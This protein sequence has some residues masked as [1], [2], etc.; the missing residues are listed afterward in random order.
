MGS[1]RYG[2][3]YW[4]MAVAVTTAFAF[5]MSHRTGNW[6]IFGIGVPLAVII[7]VAVTAWADHETKAALK[8]KTLDE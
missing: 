1:L 3:V 5:G 7:A 8:G 6:F 2:W 4:V